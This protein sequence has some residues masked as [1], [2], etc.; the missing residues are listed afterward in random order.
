[1]S[2]ID[3]LAVTAI[4]ALFGEKEPEPPKKETAQK[5]DGNISTE[6]F[7]KKENTIYPGGSAKDI[8]WRRKNPDLRMKAIHGRLMD[9]KIDLEDHGFTRDAEDISSILDWL[10][11]YEHDV[12]GLMDKPGRKDYYKLS[13]FYAD[14]DLTDY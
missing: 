12:L 10:Y 4:L 6:Y 14:Y 2:F 7:A 5:V 1:M 8:P 9:I 11:D 3:D 13:G